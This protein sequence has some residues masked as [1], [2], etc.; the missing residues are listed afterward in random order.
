MFLAAFTSLSIEVLQCGH[1]CTLTERSLFTVFPHIEHVCDVPLG[2]TR[3]ISRP[4][5]E[6]LSWILLLRYLKD[7]L[8]YPSV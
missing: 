7:A 1:S 8:L 4:A 3:I 2:S 6:A 5:L